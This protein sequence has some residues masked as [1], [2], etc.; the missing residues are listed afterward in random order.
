MER[1]NMWRVQLFE[2]NYDHREAEAVKAVVEGGWLTMGEKTV[3]FETEFEALLGSGHCTAVSSC[4][5][6]LHMSLL[7]L[8]VGPGDEVLVPGL[9][10]VAAVNAVRM[11][12]GTPVLVD[13]ESYDVWNCG[14]E[15]FAAG[16]TPRTKAVTCV[17]Y[18]GYPC[19]MDNLASLCREQG[20]PLIEDAAHSP[21]GTFGGQ[22]L[23]TWG[24]I[25][26]FSF[27][28][29]KNLS[30]GEGG[31][32][33]TGDEELHRR[34]RYLR[35]HGMTSLTLD[36]HQ[37][38]AITY[39]VVR[40]G[41]NY[42]IDEMRAAL[43]LIQLEKL[44][45]ANEERRRLVHYYHER[46]DEIDA[47]HV[48]FRRHDTGGGTYHIY[49]I[50]LAE[51]VDRDAVVGA[52][53][54]RGVQASIHYPSIAEF[55]AYSDLQSDACPIASDISRREMTLPLFPTMGDEKVDIVCEALADSLAEV[56]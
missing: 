19:R 53:R 45:A 17:H 18:G 16:I 5:A 28:T 44:A 52:L 29:N 9:T 40:P 14:V 12:G 6:A 50:L 23:G 7:A 37:G 46:M 27:F 3:A 24:D 25:G 32:L 13:C 55:Q 43:G 15:N 22:A 20:V 30:V 54:A 47:V 1:V 8:D 56:V 10:F 11:V 26:C 21:G 42:R 4:T 49:P 41:L 51:G 38:R 31:M 33:W 35:S 34:L 36:R 39:D 2:L 48:P